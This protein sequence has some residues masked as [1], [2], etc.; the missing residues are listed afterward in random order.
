MARLFVW[1]GLAAVAVGCGDGGDAG[2]S[3]GPEASLLGG[4][5]LVS[6]ASLPADSLSATVG[7]EGGVLQVGPHALSIP[8]GALAGP[9]PI[10]AVVRS[11]PVNRVE[12]QPTGLEFRAPVTLSLD[13][14]NCGELAG[15]IPKRIVWVDDASLDVLGLIASLDDLLARRVTAQLTHFSS[16]A[17]AW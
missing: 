16:Y 2:A 12:F 15:L 7:V 14:A 3:A 17:I 5:G 10:T 8:S 11:E 13:Y 1:L 6:C 4:S 9:V